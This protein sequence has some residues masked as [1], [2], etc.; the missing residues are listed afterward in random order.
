LRSRGWLS[1]WLKR[2][3]EVAEDYYTGPYR[4][5]I[6]RAKRE[7]DDFLMLLVYSEMMGIPNP[8]AFHMLELQP[9]LLERF[10]EW[11]LRMGME[12]SPLDHL[13]CC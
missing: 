13:R 9:L 1:D 3:T 5:T 7:E 2:A 6:A 12:K 10:H 4:S 8:G 11:H